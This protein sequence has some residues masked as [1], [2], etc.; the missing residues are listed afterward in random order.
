VSPSR[1]AVSQL[2]AVAQPE[3]PARKHWRPHFGVQFP[4]PCPNLA[5]RPVLPPAKDACLPAIYR[6]EIAARAEHFDGIAFAIFA[7][8]YGPDNY[9]PFAR[10]IGKIQ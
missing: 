4:R 7:P 1:E 5:F 6:G 9:T 2:A 8:G 10:L 3:G